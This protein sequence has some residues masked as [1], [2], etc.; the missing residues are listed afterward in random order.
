MNVLFSVY[1][2]NGLG[3]SCSDLTAAANYE[4]WVLNTACPRLRNVDIYW[5]K[6]TLPFYQTHYVYI[7]KLMIHSIQRDCYPLLHPAAAPLQILS[8]SRCLLKNS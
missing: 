4:P 3:K 2:Q 1:S 6:K 7:R 8:L 5:R